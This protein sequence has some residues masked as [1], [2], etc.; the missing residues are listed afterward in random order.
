MAQT[1]ISLNVSTKA[2]HQK[3]VRDQIFL[4]L[5]FTILLVL[6]LTGLSILGTVQ[7]STLINHWGNIS[8]ILLISPIL[9]FSLINLIIIVLS[10][11]GLSHILRKTPVWMAKVQQVFSRIEKQTQ[12]ICN[13]I[14]SPWIKL[15]S[16]LSSIK[17]LKNKKGA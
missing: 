9:L 3:Q 17:V 10:I 13:T 8:A 5:G 16:S 14:I 11:R 15:D 1:N 12:T 4:P 2:S 6:V 7:K